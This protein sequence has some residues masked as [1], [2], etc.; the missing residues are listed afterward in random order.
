MRKYLKFYCP[1]GLN[2]GAAQWVMIDV[3][4]MAYL[5]AA[6][7][8]ASD[9]AVYIYSVMRKNKLTLSFKPDVDATRGYLTNHILDVITKA[10]QESWTNVPYIVGPQGDENNVKYK[11][12]SG[13]LQEVHLMNITIT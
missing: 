10:E 9:T 1:N 2:G 5:D 13:N 4:N 7:G 12:G 8:G 11:D 3:S 6:A